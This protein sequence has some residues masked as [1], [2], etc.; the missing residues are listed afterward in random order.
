MQSS[1]DELKE[2]VNAYNS[3][4]ARKADVFNLLQKSGVIPQDVVFEDWM[5]E[6]R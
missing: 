6:A 4:V 1:V 2:V 3:G 5:E